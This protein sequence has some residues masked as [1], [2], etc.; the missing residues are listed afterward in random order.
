[1]TKWLLE[2]RGVIDEHGYSLRSGSLGKRFFSMDFSR[3][4]FLCGTGQKGIYCRSDAKHPI[5]THFSPV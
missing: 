3:A 4:D 5:Y 2:M 1:M